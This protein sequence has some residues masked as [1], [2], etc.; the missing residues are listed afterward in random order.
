MISLG[1]KIIDIQFFTSNGTWNKPQ[2]TKSI[3][4]IGGG[5]G[6]GGANDTTNG[7]NGGTTSFG[8]VVSFAGGAGG[9]S[10]TLDR[11]T[12]GGCTGADFCAP[13]T[14]QSPSNHSGIFGF[15]GGG[16]GNIDGISIQQNIAGSFYGS[17]GGYGWKFLKTSIDSSY[18]VTIGSGGARGPI[19]TIYPS[20]GQSGFLIV[21]SF[22]W[23]MDILFFL[24]FGFLT[25][26]INSDKNFEEVCIKKRISKDLKKVCDKAYFIDR[27]RQKWTR[28]SSKS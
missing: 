5:G 22:G 8:S 21:L 2:G 11:R 12:S 9:L 25:G 3:L 15:C 23:F 17:R 10:S 14:S 26:S 24:L 18:A 20:D 28:K 1:G 13:V 4:I 19:G 6:G 16:H 27:E 7:S